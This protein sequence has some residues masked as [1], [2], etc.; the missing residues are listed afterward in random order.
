MGNRLFDPGKELICT[1]GKS[2]A[3]L[4]FVYILRIQ[5]GHVRNRSYC[6]M[7]FFSDVV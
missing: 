5:E 2:A 7:M 3:E 6:V 4:G 1:T